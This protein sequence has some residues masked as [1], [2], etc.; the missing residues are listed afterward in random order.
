[1][2]EQDDE[3]YQSLIADKEKEQKKKQEEQEAKEKEELDKVLQASQATAAE[4]DENRRLSK[5]AALPVEPE[6]SSAEIVT[7]RFRLPARCGGRQLERRFRPG[8][9]MQLA[10]DYLECDKDLADKEWS[11]YTPCPR[12][13]FGD[14]T[15]TQSLRELGLTGRAVLLVEDE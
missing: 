14:A 5:K 4:E 3:Y 11:L 6:S 1:M 15:K 8:D 7:L 12:E 2:N 13:A 9:K 10:F